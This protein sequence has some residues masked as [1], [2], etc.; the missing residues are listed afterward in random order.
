MKYTEMSFDKKID[1]L[2]ASE[3]YCIPD[4][5][6]SDICVSSDQIHNLIYREIYNIDIFNVQDESFA[7]EILSS[8]LINF[9]HYLEAMEINK[10]K[11]SKLN[12]DMK[13]V[14]YKFFENSYNEISAWISS[15]INERMPVV[16]H[17]LRESRKN[18]EGC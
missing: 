3:C 16:T 9:S 17:D 13:E 5:A 6:L 7:C 14:A 18:F 11:K 12:F 8:L 15:K 1:Y 2:I 4:D 10:S